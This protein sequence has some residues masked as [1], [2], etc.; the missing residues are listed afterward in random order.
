MFCVPAAIQFSGAQQHQQTHHRIQQRGR[1]RETICETAA[2]KQKHTTGKSSVF[3][4]V[5]GEYIRCN[6]SEHIYNM[7][8]SVCI[9]QQHHARHHPIT[10]AAATQHAEDA[11]EAPASSSS[12]FVNQFVENACRRR[13]CFALWPPLLLLVLLASIWDVC[14][15]DDRDRL[16][17]RAM[18]SHELKTDEALTKQPTARTEAYS[19]IRNA[20]EPNDS[21]HPPPTF[22]YSYA[23]VFVRTYVLMT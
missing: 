8:T 22:G 2:R 23:Y 4:R 18:R 15:C 14:V 1:E 20:Q 12:T 10:A 17:R 3:T 6:F 7:Y 5:D 11:E 21:W 19:N 13:R 9:Q 16:V